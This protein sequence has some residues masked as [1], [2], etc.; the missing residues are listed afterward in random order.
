[1]DTLVINSERDFIKV[2][3]FFSE[4]KKLK[5]IINKDIVFTSYIKPITNLEGYTIFIEGNNHKIQNIF[6]YKE[7]SLNGLF[8]AV[9]NL[10]V[11]NLN[12]DSVNIYAGT[13][14]GSLCG[15]VSNEAVLNNVNLTSA[16]ISSEAFGG[17]LI[18]SAKKIECHDCN[19]ESE[20]HGYDV[21]GGLCGMTDL[22]IKEN[23]T[24]NSKVMGFL[25]LI[26]P[27]VG[28]CEETREENTS[29]NK[30]RRKLF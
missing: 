18:G 22:Y 13:L 12:I 9:K 4:D 16:K 17:G 3:S 11:N 23:T 8:S 2:R 14:T 19:V 20:V 27:E 6:I 29:V 25:K 30:K 24:V 5:L 28:Y 10:Y 21:V 26:G 15:D 7:S 1:M